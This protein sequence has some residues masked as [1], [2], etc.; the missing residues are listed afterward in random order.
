MPRSTLFVFFTIAIWSSCESSPSSLQRKDKH[1]LTKFKNRKPEDS[2]RCKHKEK[3][4]LD[5]D[6]DG[7]GNSK[8]SKMSC[9]QT[10]NYIKKSGDCDD[11]DS[12]V[13]PQ[14]K[15]YFSIPRKNGSFDFDCDD[16]ET[17]RLSTRAY[18]HLQED[19]KGCKLASGWDI[20]AS[21]KIPSCGQPEKWAWNE[22]RSEIIEPE[23]KPTKD[24]SGQKTDIT[25][26]TALLP[27]SPEGEQNKTDNGENKDDKDDEDKQD[28]IK[29]VY[30]CWKGTL[31]WKKRQLC[32]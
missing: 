31:P 1:L 29:K 2:H 7:W 19:N 5:K 16:K 13:H 8:I 25:E 18:C 22:C 11:N 15:S 17:I 28:K 23:P 27:E 3:F 26:E 10:E 20:S 14:Q 32:R 24:A 6:G 12:R 21:Q 30:S 4:Y 9:G